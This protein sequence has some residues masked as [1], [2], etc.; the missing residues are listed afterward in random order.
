[1][2][3]RRAKIT[4]Q[5]DTVGSKNADAQGERHP[6]NSAH[7]CGRMLSSRA[8]QQRCEESWDGCCAE[9]EH[10]RIMRCSVPSHKRWELARGSILVLTFLAIAVPHPPSVIGGNIVQL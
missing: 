3:Q 4:P 10:G 2:N 8:T 6:K 9:R 5:R 7:T 1:M